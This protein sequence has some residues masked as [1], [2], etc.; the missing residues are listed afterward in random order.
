LRQG[1]EFEDFYQANYGRLGALLIGVLGDRQEADDLAQEAFARALARWPRLS[2]YESPEAWIRRV[3]LRL[4]VDS[5]RRPRRTLRL[6]DKLRG[7]RPPRTGR[8]APRASCSSRGSWPRRAKRTP[9]LARP[10]GLGRSPRGP[11]VCRGFAGRRPRA[12]E[13]VRGISSRRP[14]IGGTAAS[15]QPPRESDIYAFCWT[16]SF[17]ACP[18][19]MSA[20]RAGA[21]A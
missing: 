4:A 19:A 5:G 6:S 12:R 17:P 14:M 18:Q 2:G 11:G 3:T 20:P 15:G 21:R 10:A 13:P 9:G 16:T 7:A 8:G 1:N